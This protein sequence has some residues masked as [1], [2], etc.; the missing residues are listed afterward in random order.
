[1]LLG[2]EVVVSATRTA[3][4]SWSRSTWA[5]QVSHRGGVGA[6]ARGER[7]HIRV[8]EID[9][10]EIVPAVPAGEGE[11]G[12]AQVTVERSRKRS[13]PAAISGLRAKTRRR[14]GFVL[15]TMSTPAPRLV[16]TT[17]AETGGALSML[18]DGPPVGR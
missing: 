7:L 14:G 11:P 3:S 4:R 15:L 5:K 6:V 16:I 10:P 9:A 1:M 8:A 18:S 2:D 17:P 13:E 12:C